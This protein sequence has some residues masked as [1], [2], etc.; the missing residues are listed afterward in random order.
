MADGALLLTTFIW[1]FSF[2]VVKH[3]LREIPV[4]YFNALRFSAAI[5]VFLPFMFRQWKNSKPSL[6][7]GLILAFFLYLGFAFQAA[8]LQYTTPSKSAFITASSVIGVPIFMFIFFRKKSDIFALVGVVIASA[9]L[10]FL[11]VPPNSLGLNHGD[12]L[13]AVC[14]VAW[15]FH[16]IFTGR[17][18]RQHPLAA[19]A[20]VQILFTGLGFWLTT[21]LL[22]QAG[23]VGQNIIPAILYS[24]ILATSVCFAL[25]LWA[26]RH[27]S[28]TRAG[29]LLTTEPLFA[30]ATSYFWTG[31][32]LT[33]REMSG[34]ILIIA[35]V[36]MAEAGYHWKNLRART[37]SRSE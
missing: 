28:A 17:F 14:A 36:V 19:L 15:A 37:G 6:V 30:A 24:G 9:G 35:G 34:G 1:G 20:A 25:Q 11:G 26:Q 27:T 3:A 8:G 23:P 32:R 16:I 22:G 5:L 33:G 18:S 10:Y 2:V 31:E 4:F 12:S 21:L 7:P 29:L 13:T